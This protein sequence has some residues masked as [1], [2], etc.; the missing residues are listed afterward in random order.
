MSHA[1]A[2]VDGL[3]S[4]GRGGGESVHAG[5]GVFPRVFGVDASGG[6]DGEARVERAQV[7][8]QFGQLV[9]RDLVELDAVDAGPGNGPARG[10]AGACAGGVVP[11]EGERLLGV[12][13]DEQL[14]LDA[15]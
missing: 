10:G 13:L 6:D 12:H 8:H 9:D 1:D 2:H 5:G 7:A 3:G 15:T 14:L 4:E 11:C